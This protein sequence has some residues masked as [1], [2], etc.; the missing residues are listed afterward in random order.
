MFRTALN[1]IACVVACF[2]MGL[3]VRAADAVG[4]EYAV[5]LA[6]LSARGGDL[7]KLV[8]VAE[9]ADHAQHVPPGPFDDAYMRRE[10]SARARVAGA[11]DVIDDTLMESFR[12]VRTDT[13][14]LDASRLNLLHANVVPAAEAWARLA[15]NPWSRINVLTLSR[16]GF[17]RDGSRALFAA[18]VGCGPVCGGG[19]YVLMATRG[20]QWQ[21]VAEL[22]T[23]LS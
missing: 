18:A 13:V 4:D 2:V 11:P 21:I 19:Q 8:V 6:Y 5:Y 10:L 7:S 9:T 17:N 14:R 23:W 15:A 12:R 1:I 3:S 20:G 16:V 22:A